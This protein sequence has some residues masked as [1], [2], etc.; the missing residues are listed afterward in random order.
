MPSGSADPRRLF[1]G[2]T[3]VAL[4]PSDPPRGR[5]HFPAGWPVTRPVPN[6]D[7][8][9]AASKRR[10][11]DRHESELATS[12]DPS[13]GAARTWLAQAASPLPEREFG[14]RQKDP[15]STTRAPRA[16]RA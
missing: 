5:G 2:G 15:G 14:A 3:S 8:V 6:F 11:L 13:I 7:H 10:V 4:G 12:A 1:F 9:T 16:G